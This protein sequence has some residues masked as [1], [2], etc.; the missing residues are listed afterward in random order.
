MQAPTTKMTSARNACADIPNSLASRIRKLGAQARSQQLLTPNSAYTH[1]GVNDP[2]QIH[3]QLHV[4]YAPN[5]TVSVWALRIP[6]ALP[7]RRPAMRPVVHPGPLEA[8]AN[9]RSG[10]II[11]V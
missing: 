2:L 5:P 3:I 9:S 6:M 11:P 4:H 7:T 1:R 8:Q 10:L